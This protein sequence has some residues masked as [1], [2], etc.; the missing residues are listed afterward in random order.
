MR[1]VVYFFAWLEG[2]WDR[3]TESMSDA[4]KRGYRKGYHGHE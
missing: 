4:Q 2:K 1:S 3:Y